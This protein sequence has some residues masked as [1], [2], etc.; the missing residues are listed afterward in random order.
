M[1]DSSN[2]SSIASSPS[3][4][5]PSLVDIHTSNAWPPSPTTFQADSH[6]DLNDNHENKPL[7]N[8]PYTCSRTLTLA[9]LIAQ[10]EGYLGKT[11]TI[12]EA[13]I[14]YLIFNLH[15]AVSAGLFNFTELNSPKL[16]NA[17]E[18]VGRAF[19]SNFSSYLYTPTNLLSDRANLNE[20]WY[21]VNQDF[22]TTSDYYT[23]DIDKDGFASSKDGWPG[24]GYIEFALGKR[25]LLGW[26][27]IDSS[28]L[29]YNF[30]GDSSIIF[31]HNYLTGSQ[32]NTSISNTDHFINGCFAKN[33][34]QTNLLNSSWAI[35]PFFS[36][37]K[38][39]TG[40]N[41][42]KKKIKSSR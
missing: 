22:K 14:I 41:D 37:F 32:N 1:S 18:L 34:T 20:S 30:S 2:R 7:V 11:D 5:I 16:P 9:S 42:G 15:L 33:E 17:Q 26:G 3:A 10:I 31:S 38:Y 6:S 27:S 39:P 24:E 4:F 36:N 12:L 19:P 23:E 35:E 28:M 13:R 21:N 40:R 8:V 29:G 25:V